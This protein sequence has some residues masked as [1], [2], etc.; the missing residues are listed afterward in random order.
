M[1]QFS[2]AASSLGAQGAARGRAEAAGR[3]GGYGLLG[4]KATGPGPR[5]TA[6]GGSKSGGG[7]E[8][9]GS[10]ASRALNLAPGKSRLSV[11]EKAS[12]GLPLDEDELAQLSPEQRAYWE[13]QRAS[14]V[15]G[16]A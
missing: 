9:R 10:A 1:A 8:N 3:G 4:Y 14:Q 5:S 12:Q 11:F 15:L 2:G 13:S 6:G 16:V 7:G